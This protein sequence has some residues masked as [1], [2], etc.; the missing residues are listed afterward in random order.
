MRKQQRDRG[1]RDEEEE[2]HSRKEEGAG[3]DWDTK[4]GEM[5]P[6]AQDS[7]H[8]LLS[9]L[10]GKLWSSGTSVCEKCSCDSC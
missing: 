4:Q 1:R 10:P 8:F 9:A 5:S 2:G 7:P 6:R 3:R